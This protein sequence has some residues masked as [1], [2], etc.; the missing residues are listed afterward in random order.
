M[1]GKRPKLDFAALVTSIRETDARL[2]TQAIRSVNLGLTL[3]NWAIGFHI[4]EFELRGADRAA[5]GDRL[6]SE[7]AKALGNHGISYTG[8]RQLYQYLAFYRAYPQ[9]VRTVPAQFRALLPASAPSG[10]VPTVSAQSGLPPQKLLASLSYSHFELLV[11]REDPLARSFYEVECIRGNW[12]IRELKR[13][14]G[15][16]YFERSGLSTDKKAL[17]S[18]L[19]S[20]TDVD[21]VSAAIRDPYV[22]E[23]LGIRPGQVMSE[24]QLEDGLLD[25]LQTFLLELGNGFC[26]E[27]RQKRILIGR[28]HGFVDL[29]FYHRVLKCHV[30]IELKVDDFNHEHL[31]QLNTYVSW[32][33]RNVMTKGDNPPI[34]LLMCTDKDH[35]LV[36]Y[37]LAD[38]PNR[39]FVSKYQLELPT[40]DQLQKFLDA[41]LKEVGDA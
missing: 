7:L 21:S 26:F 20:A 3:R 9:I 30:L 23:F 16:L 41:Q 33:K 37:A 25:K 14:I 27:A 4:A 5:Y 19:K 12:S 22:F 11:R 24:S 34:G 18:R 6:L 2:L 28:T 31:G 36:E 13:Q 8:R 35:S 17:A 40:R 10:K 38:L 39:L 32:Y 29:V 1:A 15:R